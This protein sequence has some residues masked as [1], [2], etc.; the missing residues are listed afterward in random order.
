M[1]TPEVVQSKAAATSGS[2]CRS[3]ESAI[4]QCR[5]TAGKALAICSAGGATATYRYGSAKPEIEVESGRWARVGYSG[6]GELQIAFDNGDTTYVVFSRT[7]R[8]NFTADK[9][10]NPAMSDGVIVLRQGKFAGM[11]L[12]ADG[13]NGADYNES[14]EAAMQRLPQSDDLFTDETYRADPEGFE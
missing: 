3:G 1:S 14:T 11:Q 8:T 6:G 9:P 5:T 4:H 2:G 7:I 12:C 10:N 13:G